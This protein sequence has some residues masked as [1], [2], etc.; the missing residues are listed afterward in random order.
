MSKN[1]TRVKKVWNWIE[2]IMLLLVTLIAAVLF[3]LSRHWKPVLTSEIK[4]IVLNSTDSLYSIDFDDIDIN[5]LTGNVSVRNIVFKSDS[6]VYK[7]LEQNFRAPKHLFE[8]EV[9]WLIL[10]RVHPWKTYFDR[11][12][13]MKSI[14]ITTPVIRVIY[15]K[16]SRTDSLETDT[17]TAYQRLS[18]YL[19]SVKVEKVV[20][21][22]ADF[23]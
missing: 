20:F 5:L 11:E 15:E 12:L 22:D 16:N 2:G 7:K 14:I 9:S 1:K 10:N 19:K 17:R 8:I 23:K 18:K 21:S 4:Q 6:A 13:Q 3:Y